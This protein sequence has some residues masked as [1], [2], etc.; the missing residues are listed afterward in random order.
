MTFSWRKKDFLPLEG[1]GRSDAVQDR[2]FLWFKLPDHGVLPEDRQWASSNACWCPVE[3]ARPKRSILPSELESGD[4]G[5]GEDR[6]CHGCRYF[7]NDELAR[8]ILVR[9]AVQGAIDR[10]TSLAFELLGRVGVHPVAGGREFNRR[11]ALRHLHPPPRLAAEANALT[12]IW[13]VVR[14]W[15]DQRTLGIGVPRCVRACRMA[16]R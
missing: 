6:P 16:A 11:G 9:Y 14:C 15:T 13:R 12:R 3:A 10:A 4:G 7:C 8:M 2:G 1:P 5:A